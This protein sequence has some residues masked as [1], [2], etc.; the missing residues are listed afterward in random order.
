MATEGADD[1]TTVSWAGQITG[2]PMAGR[3]M[4]EE[5]NRMTFR[6]LA[7]PVCLA[8][9]ILVLSGQMDFLVLARWLRL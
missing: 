5:I 7:G 1:I 2:L 4:D 8:I 3:G 9:V 6:L